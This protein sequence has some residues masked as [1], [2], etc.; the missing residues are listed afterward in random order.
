VTSHYRPTPESLSLDAAAQ[1]LKTGA[2]AR[3]LE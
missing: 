3:A 1:M 2:A